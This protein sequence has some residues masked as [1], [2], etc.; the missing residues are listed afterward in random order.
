MD[1]LSDKVHEDIL[2]HVG[3]NLGPGVTAVGVNQAV[4]L[5]QEI[6]FKVEK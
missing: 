1:K 3:V 4:T 5:T 2:K 6:M